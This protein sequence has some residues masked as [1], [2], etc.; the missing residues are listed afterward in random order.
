MIKQPDHNCSI[1]T[2]ITAEKA[3]EILTMWQDGEQ[4]VLKDGSQNL[5]TLSPFVF[6]RNS[7]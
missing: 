7:S 6:G 5:T 3:F 1:T 2:N 4:K